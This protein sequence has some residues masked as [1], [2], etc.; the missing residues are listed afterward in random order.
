MKVLS[1]V[2]TSTHIKGLVLYKN[3][4]QARFECSFEDYTPFFFDKLGIDLNKHVISFTL[5]Q[6][7]TLYKEKT[8]Q[9]VPK[10]S[11]KNL[12]YF[13]E[14]SLFPFEDSE[15]YLVSEIKR[16]KKN[17]HLKT[18]ACLKASC[19]QSWDDLVCLGITPD[20]FISWQR[21]LHEGCLLVSFS[22][23][24]RL[25]FY[26]ENRQVL[27]LYSNDQ[28]LL[29]STALTV[30][31]EDKKNLD[32]AIFSLKQKIGEDLLEVIIIGQNGILEDIVQK[33]FP[34]AKHDPILEENHNLLLMLGS[35]LLSSRNKG[36][37]LKPS[38][39]KSKDSSFKEDLLRKLT[40]ANLL[41]SGLAA[42]TLF[43]AF[44]Y[45]NQWAHRAL[46][47]SGQNELPLFISQKFVQKKLSYIDS[48]KYLLPIIPQIPTP[49]EVLVF[50]S[51]H[52][53]L[54]QI[55]SVSG[56]NTSFHHFSYKLVDLKTLKINFS[57]QFPHSSFQVQFEKDLKLKKI[58]FTPSHSSQFIDYEIIIKK[59]Q[60][61]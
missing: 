2:L 34:F 12:V 17:L 25:I 58:T 20:F 38:I 42:I 51:A 46:R 55:D 21:A 24:N 14:K 11:L 27:V 29:F 4:M 56:K 40:Q 19:A 26:I 8:F 7:T 47:Q 59:G 37:L 60:R 44:I 57:C 52:P 54:N 15:A 39:G 16:E 30:H 5:G 43:S 50:L 36:N 61:L 9:N 31:N 49:A 35:G 28:N 13:Y 10:T 41:L 18:H 45:Q 32:A 48:L 1:L 3:R 22:T 33:N 6:H 53:V 23:T